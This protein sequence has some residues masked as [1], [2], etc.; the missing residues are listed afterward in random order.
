M[1]SCPKREKES[2]ILGVTVRT[3]NWGLTTGSV[4]STSVFF[5]GEEQFVWLMMRVAFWLVQ[6]DGKDHSPLS[7][8][9]VMK[10][11]P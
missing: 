4:R 2:Y 8:G 1:F 11:T 3:R 6:Q 5:F 7:A 10:L 9:N